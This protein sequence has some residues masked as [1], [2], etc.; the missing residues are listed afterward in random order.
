MHFIG[1]PK[2][3]EKCDGI[4]LIERT[5][6]DLKDNTSISWAITLK[7]DWTLIGMIGYYRMKLE[8]H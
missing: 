2:A 1:K 8:H 4:E 7:E 5:M 3:I 6:R